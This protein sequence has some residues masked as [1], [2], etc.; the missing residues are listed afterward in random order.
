MT[1]ATVAKAWA[2]VAALGLVATLASSLPAL[3]QPSYATHQE[4][5]KG[6]IQSRSGPYTLYVRARNGDL[7]H[8]EMHQGTIINPTG[9][10]LEAGMH[11]TVYGHGAGPVFDA[12]EIDT[13]YHY[14]PPIY[15]YPGG[16]WYGWPHPWGWGWGPGWGFGW[17]W[18][19][20]WW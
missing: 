11:V 15:Y 4:S 9:L 8:V 2:S 7:D 13:P 14:T 5:I 6:T 19:P 16:P 18:N 12:N 10:T 3:A 17:G 1:I 20:W